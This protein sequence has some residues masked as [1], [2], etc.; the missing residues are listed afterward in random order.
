VSYN[1]TEMMKGDIERV[2][3]MIPDPSFIRVRCAGK[4]KG[5]VPFSRGDHSFLASRDD[6][7]G[8]VEYLDKDMN[9]LAWTRLGD[10]G[11]GIKAGEEVRVHIPE[12]PFW[13]FE[14]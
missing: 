7:E 2:L 4:K 9:L 8:R 12:G 5:T 14:F 1:V 13:T 3:A 6:L 10:P 11:I